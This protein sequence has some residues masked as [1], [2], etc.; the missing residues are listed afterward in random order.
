MLADDIFQK[1]LD[2][3]VSI[4]NPTAHDFTCTVVNRK[5]EPIEYTIYSRESLTLPRYAAEH[6]ANKLKDRMLAEY[7]GV[8]TQAIQEEKLKLIKLYE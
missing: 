1:N 6:V 7:T 2:E 4:V 8:I 5:D 3:L